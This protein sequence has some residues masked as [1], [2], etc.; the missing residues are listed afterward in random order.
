MARTSST[1]KIVKTGLA[2]AGGYAAGKA[3]ASIP[4][5]QSNPLFAILAPVGGA[6]LTPML[7]GKGATAKTIAAGMVAAAA[8]S[9]VAQY[10][11]GVASSVGLA[12]VPFRSTLT[13]G[14]AGNG[15]YTPT[16]NF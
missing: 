14:V 15:Q 3:V 11:P 10:A 16:I 8:T 6:I 1:S 4:F 2:V 7:L 13:P 5:V 9:A 12:G